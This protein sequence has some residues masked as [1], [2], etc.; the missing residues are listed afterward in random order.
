[1]ADANHATIA[2]TFSNDDVASSAMLALKNAGLVDA[3]R[4]GAI[5]KERASTIAHS[6]AA[7]ADVDPLDPLSGVA[8]VASGGDA[9]SG[10]NRGAVIGGG[11]GAA[12]G[13]LGGNTS[14]GAVMPAE[15]S[16][17]A[18]AA[19]M[20][21]FALGVAVGG[22]LGGAFGKRP[23]THAGFRLIDAMEAGEIAAIGSVLT[24]RSS[25]AR[26]MLEDNGAADIIVIAA[27]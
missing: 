20:L 5:D 25:E 26:K 4:V 27:N 22:V 18:I 11:V 24:D 19:A 15:P 9:A 14:L 8:G 2:C 1:M 6:L 10:V 3:W 21:F 7:D 13:F 17:R 12:A 23:S 16:L